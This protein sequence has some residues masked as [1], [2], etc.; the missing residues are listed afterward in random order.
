ME[1]YIYMKIR[2]FVTVVLFF[3]LALPAA[4][5]DGIYGSAGF[6]VIFSEDEDVSQ[7]YYKPFARMGWSGEYFD[8]S[9]SYYRWMS[10]TVTD[11][12]YNEREID[13]NQPGADLTIY[14]GDILSV[15]GGYSYI[16]GSSSYTAH[17]YSGEIILD[18]E[19]IDIS[20]DSSFK[21]TEYEF[22]GTI[23]NS[24]FTAGGE[25]SF[26]VTESFSWDAGYL[27]EKTD[28]KTY[29]YIYTK[30]SGRLGIVLSPMEKL[31]FLG[32]ITG[33]KDSDNIKSAAF[34]AGFSLKL[35]KHL[36]LSAA[37]MLT[38]EFISS[39]S[40]S[41]SSGRRGT[42]TTTTTE[43]EFSHTGNI[44]VSLYF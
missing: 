37:Y 26:D 41:T 40:S 15:S 5:Q 9:A 36:K 4:A 20:A 21:N 6:R 17:K 30:N 8:I 34:D 39:G 19:S 22:N 11:A 44:A 16:S 12:L 28:Y 43:T 42:S 31:Y 1:D 27:Y 25:V 18:F 23:K 24:Y 10:Y 3:F 38:A 14:A 32:G 29:G 35:F 33:G 2:R 13:L 7:H